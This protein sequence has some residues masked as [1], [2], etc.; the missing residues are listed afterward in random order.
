MQQIMT[1]LGAS[2]AAQKTQQTLV[3]TISAFSSWKSLDEKQRRKLVLY[4]LII[5]AAGTMIFVASNQIS[6]IQPAA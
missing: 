6:K 1:S 5:L 4:S 3:N 2:F